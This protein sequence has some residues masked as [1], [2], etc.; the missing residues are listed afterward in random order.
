MLQ[1]YAPS[2]TVTVYG[3]AEWADKDADKKPTGLLGLGVKGLGP[4]YHR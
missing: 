2:R 1:V 3:P 4:Y